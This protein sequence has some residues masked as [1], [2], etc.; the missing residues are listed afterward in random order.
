MCLRRNGVASQQE[1]M[2]STL[3]ISFSLTHQRIEVTEQATTKTREK[4]RRK[5]RSLHLKEK[6]EPVIRIEVNCWG[7][8]VG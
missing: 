7:L 5:Y 2:L 1:K 3:K 6:L 8:S 4:I